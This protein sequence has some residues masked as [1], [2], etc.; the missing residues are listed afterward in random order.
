MISLKN[1]MASRR[2]RADLGVCHIG[3]KYPSAGASERARKEISTAAVVS[4]MIFVSAI[5]IILGVA[6]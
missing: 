4:A 3:V 6:K 1:Q 2:I 5:V